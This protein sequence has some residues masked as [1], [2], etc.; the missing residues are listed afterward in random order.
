MPR[1]SSKHTTYINNLVLILF[2][3]TEHSKFASLKELLYRFTDQTLVY[4]IEENFANVTKPEIRP[5][6]VIESTK[7]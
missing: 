2:G 3:R 4:F 6:V 1:G 5:K 7:I